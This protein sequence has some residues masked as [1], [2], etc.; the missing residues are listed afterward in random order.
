M[1]NKVI[2]IIG[3]ILLIV[4]IIFI[5]YTGRNMYIISKLSN[6][7]EETMQ[8]TNYKK[9]VYN[10]DLDNYTKE[11]TLVMEDKIKIIR[12]EISGDDVITITTYGKHGEKIDDSSNKYLVNMYYD[13]KEDKKAILNKEI[14]F[15][16]NLENEIYT[17]NW[18]QLFTKSITASIKKTT[19]REKECY[20]ITNFDGPNSNPQESIYIDKD[21]GMPIYT[22]GLT[23]GE[24]R[25]GIDSELTYYSA[26]F[27]YKYEFD[28]VTEDDFK[29]PDIS[30]YEI[31]KETIYF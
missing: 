21:T 5:S 16:K 6:N 22:I 27:E 25:P 3:I 2:K 28:N 19:F 9:I 10:Y 18:W 26:I 30:D 24:I 31:L 8:S 29:E 11:E 20:C 13:N 23:R 4:L 15:T 7:A 17:E 12:T 1:K 14:G